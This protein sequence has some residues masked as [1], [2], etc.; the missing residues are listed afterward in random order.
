MQSGGVAWPSQRCRPRCRAS[1]PCAWWKKRCPKMIP[2]PRPWRAMACCG[3]APLRRRSSSGSGLPSGSLAV[4]CHAS[5]WTGAA[6]AWRPWGSGPGSWCG[7]GQGLVAHKPGG[8]R[9][10]ACP[11]VPG[12]TDGRR[13]LDARM[14][15]AEQKSLAEPDRA[16]MGAWKTCR[17][18]ISPCLDSTGGRRAGVCLLW[19]CA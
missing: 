8:T 2:S 11:Q 9:R 15:A 18:G 4:R 12:E 14:S 13:C 10:D 3:A 5:V 1:M 7:M 16:Q 17:D 19:L 6:A